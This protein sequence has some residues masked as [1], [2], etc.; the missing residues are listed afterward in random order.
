MKITNLFN[1]ILG[2]SRPQTRTVPL[3]MA[4][5]NPTANQ[6]NFLEGPKEDTLD[7]S[8]DK[9]KETI[10][11]QALQEEK[12]IEAIA[13][14]EKKPTTKITRDGFTGLRDKSCL[15]RKLDEKI[16]EAYQEGETLTVA[17]FDMDNFKS[18]NELLS[19]ET[20]D[21][22]IQ[23]IGH[24]VQNVARE[25]NLG[26][27]RFGGEEFVIILKGKS[28]TGVEKICTEVQRRITSNELI[29]HYSEIYTDKAKGVISECMDTQCYADQINRTK[30]KIEVLKK[31]MSK[32]SSLSMN[33]TIQESL[34]S[35][36]RELVILY[37]SILRTLARDEKN[38]AISNKL[39]AYMYLLEVGDEEDRK[40]IIYN[41]E[42]NNYIS[43]KLEKT[44]QIAYA[45]TWLN[46]YKK[47]GGFTI[48]C[49]IIEMTPEF[50]KNA[51]A[52]E[53]IDEAGEVLKNGKHTQKGGVYFRLLK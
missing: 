15:L 40:E 47:N 44:A 30:I 33:G 53:V 11:P 50:L 22:F 13:I 7:F 12:P 51:K 1:N 8:I 23:E 17:M 45:K 41:E 52:K 28:R 2:L 14:E 25:N 9:A 42:V 5:T 37:K 10:K 46:D 36:K 19:Y 16:K 35:S 3:R 26:S 24:S 6:T 4:A 20:G 49:G 32:D 39:Y 29:S 21:D 43:T 34:A 18:I 38:Q 27:Y 48:T 31:L